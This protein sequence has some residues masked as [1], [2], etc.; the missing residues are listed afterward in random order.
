MTTDFE[1]RLFEE[2]RVRYQNLLREFA[3]DDDRI[4][5][6]FK[7]VIPATYT[8]ESTQ[9]ITPATASDAIQNAADH[10]LSV[11]R[12]AVPVRPVDTDTIGAQKTAERLQDF[13]QKWWSNA[14]VYCGD[15]LGRAKVPLIKGK[16]VLKKTLRW[17]LIDPIPEDATP[18][19]KKKWRRQLEKAGRSTF[20]WNIDVIPKET[21]FEDIR[22][23]YD[24]PDIFEAY[25]ITYKDAFKK[26]PA[27]KEKMG[28]ADLLS[29]VEYVEY[30]LRPE[31]ESKGK[32]IQWVA[33]D[34]VHESDNPYCWEHPLSTE[35]HPRYD[36]YIPYVIGD[37]GWGDE[38]V[39]ALPEDRYVSL[40]KPSRAVLDAECQMMTTMNEYMKM[41]V[42]KPLITKNVPVNTAL[43]MTPGAHWDLKDDQ[44]AEFLQPGEMPVSLLQALDR[45]NQA[46]D[47]T[48]KFGALGGVAQRGVDTATEQA[49]L[50]TNASAK[51]SGPIRTLRRLVM[52]LNM[53]IAQDIEKVIEAPVTIY[54]ATSGASDVTVKPTDFN[55]FYLTDVEMETSDEAAVMMRQARVWADLAQRLTIPDTFV[56]KMAGVQN[57]SQLKDEWLMEQLEKAPQTLQAL[58]MM[59][60]QGIG[61]TGQ[62]VN[63][64]MRMQL[65]APGAQAGA[66][67]A[68]AT[69]QPDLPTNDVAAMRQQAQVD[70][71]QN[72]PD[73]SLQ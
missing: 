25:E 53:Q 40:I 18:A 60:L 13:Y 27:L 6:K 7:N 63:D 66:T 19:E 68:Q 71:V 41:Y 73:R 15:P 47:K 42:F 37:P 21:V 49:N 31:G 16:V 3:E 26:F 20:L 44:E 65:M 24:S 2:T 36:G 12:I 48:T 59:M 43:P 35:A 39:D 45:V 1:F 64:S 33:G 17:D 38:S 46:A 52:Q 29:K 56:L 69:V 61:E 10:I 8:D 51:L 58:L 23:P 72:M 67:P 70:A 34:R 32:F 62:M 57:G 4:H 14:F 5:Q 55:G 22:R 11:P 9:I 30:W 28:D 50:S 54:G